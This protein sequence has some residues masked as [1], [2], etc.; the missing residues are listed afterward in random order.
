MRH[1]YKKGIN[2]VF[3]KNYHEALECC[4]KV[5]NLKP[6]DFRAYYTKGIIFNKLKMLQEAIESYEKALKI[7]PEMMI[8]GMI[9]GRL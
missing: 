1:G 4:D 5:I 3:L 9:K 7:D 6:E 8:Y 2:L